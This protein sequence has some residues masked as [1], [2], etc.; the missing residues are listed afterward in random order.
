MLIKSLLSIA[1][2]S[3][4]S[5]CAIT[6]QSLRL[7]ITTSINLSL[8]KLAVFDTI[9]LLTMQVRIEHPMVAA[10]SGTL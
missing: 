9:R 2:C 10:S 5:F 1:A 8:D 7:V 6:L 4:A 3:A